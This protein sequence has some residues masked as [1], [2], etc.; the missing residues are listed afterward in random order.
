MSSP[1]MSPLSRAG[2]F[3]LVEMMVA[4]AIGV[5]LMIALTDLLVDVKGTFVREDQFARLQEGAR[6]SI[7]LA[8]NHMRSTRS[9]GCRSLAM[10]EFEGSFNVK[11]CKLID[12]PSDNTCKH[13]GWQDDA[14]FLSMDRALGY[15]NSA[16]L[17][18]AGNLSDLPADGAAN[19]ADRWLRGDILVTWGVD[20]EGAAV[21]SRLK[22]DVS[23]DG[24]LLGRGRFRIAAPVDGLAVGKLALITDCVGA[25]LFEISGP[26]RLRAGGSYAIAHAVNAYD[27]EE[28]GASVNASDAFDRAYNWAD[29]TAGRQI[30][31]TVHRAS[32]YPFSY[33]VYYICCVDTDQRRLQTGKA[34]TQCSDDDSDLDRYR[35]SLCAWS[36]EVGRS[37]VLI[38]DVADMRVTYTGDL[39]DDGTLD[40]FA[41]DIS[42]VPTAAWVT[43]RNGGAGAWTNVR[44]AAVE[45][46]IASGQDHVVTTSKVPA[47]DAWPP[48]SG[49]GTIAID[50]LGKGMPA[51]TRLYQRFVINVAM[52]ASTPW[53][54]DP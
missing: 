1:S 33:N 37:E 10:A 31:Q 25:D 52:R 23:D 38:N 51:D 53:Y 26:R 28:T 42:P 13:A 8:S 3:S 5:I 43:A 19:V 4:V 46:L 15:D 50:T 20:G 54:I 12:T 14:H 39:N 29:D 44:S 18:T 9:L 49:N 47:D 40:F 48:S 21:T 27:D 7:L 6:I 22:Q 34:V 2:G 11:A 35:P 41:D 32:V 30:A 24:G 36:L 45:L 17:S 16:D